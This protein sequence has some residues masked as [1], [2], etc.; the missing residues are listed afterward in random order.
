MDETQEVYIRVL[1]I[2]D[3]V[4]G[5]VEFKV[6]ETWERCWTT[7]SRELIHR[8]SHSIHPAQWCAE[9]MQLIVTIALR[10]QP[11]GQ[12]IRFLLLRGHYAVCADSGGVHARTLGTSLP[13]VSTTAGA[14]ESLAGEM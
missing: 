5:L 7:A 3:T 8:L 9:N 2:V 12:P 11:A 14:I 4:C 13:A 1:P 6:G 10:G